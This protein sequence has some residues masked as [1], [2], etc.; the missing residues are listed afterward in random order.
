M[1][2][3]DPR[4]YGPLEVCQICLIIAWVRWSPPALAQMLMGDSCPEAE[5]QKSAGFYFVVFL[6]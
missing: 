6:L 2:P 3:G 5:G 4:D 1:L